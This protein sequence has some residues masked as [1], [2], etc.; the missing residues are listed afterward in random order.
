MRQRNAAVALVVA[1]CLGLAGCTA[2]DDA[3]GRADGPSQT[4]T[5]EPSSSPTAEPAQP[6]EP[7][8]EPPAD[9]PSA[10]PGTPAAPG[11]ETPRRSAEPPYREP[12]PRSGG[13]ATATPGPSTAPTRPSRPSQPSAPP[14]S[15]RE[16]GGPSGA[17]AFGQTYVWDNGLTITAG[18]PTQLAATEETPGGE[19]AQQGDG[20]AAGAPAPKTPTG[21]AAQSPPPEGPDGPGAT[22]SA[23]RTEASP[24]AD[25]H[26]GA[27]AAF[28]AVPAAVEGDPVGFDAAAP[29]ASTAPPTAEV[30]KVDLMIVNGTDEPINTSFFVAMTSGGA[31]APAVYDP[32]AGLTG[33][34]G[35]MLQPG[36]TARFT[37][38]FEAQDPDDLTMEI[39]PAY[40]YVSAI[41][42]RSSAA[43]G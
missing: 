43:Q 18:R 14:P 9:P 19:E 39:R 2:D 16:V 6:S 22:T 8:S 13:T 37:V 30:T 10:S 38:G 25:A 21:P 27:E 31:D 4:A 20:P 33:P 1:T 17:L 15:P 3:P 32:A 29:T 35:T 28:D 41:F 12:L 26:P 40:H 23:A 11:P 7:S 5:A 34:P 36:R 42:V 24:A